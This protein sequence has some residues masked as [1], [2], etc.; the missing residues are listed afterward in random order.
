MLS[1]FHF[2]SSVSEHG[3]MQGL[4][5]EER[6]EFTVHCLWFWV[7]VLRGVSLVNQAAT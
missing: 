5:G 7:L 2:T 3:G 1:G 6:M 4:G